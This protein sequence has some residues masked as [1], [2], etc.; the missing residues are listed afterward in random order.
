MDMKC[1]NCGE[2]WDMDYVLHEAP[3]DFKRKGSRITACPACKGDK[4]K[5][6]PMSATYHALADIAGDDID[7]FASDLEDFGL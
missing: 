3:E 6:H 1:A 4:S 5:R 2:P 7:G